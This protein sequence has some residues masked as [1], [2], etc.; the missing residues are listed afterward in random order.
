MSLLQLSLQGH[1]VKDKGDAAD[2]ALLPVV[3]HYHITDTT[4]VKN[5]SSLLCM[6]IVLY[7]S[8]QCGLTGTMLQAYC[9]I[10]VTVVLLILSHWNIDL[11]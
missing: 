9:V 3:S 11:I 1:S 5:H 10:V 4:S 2:R 7:G 6:S 8:L